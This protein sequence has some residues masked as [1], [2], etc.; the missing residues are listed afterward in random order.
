M[1]DSSTETEARSDGR[2]SGK[3]GRQGGVR[4]R[5]TDVN[6][7]VKAPE[8]AYYESKHHRPDPLYQ[9]GTLDTTEGGGGV[10]GEIHNSSTA[11]AEARAHNLVTAARALDPTD[12]AVPRELVTLPEGTV[13][14]SGSAKTA[15]EGMEDIELALDDM[16]DNPALTGAVGPA[17]QA[18]AEEQDDDGDADNDGKPDALERDKGTGSERDSTRPTGD[19]PE[20]SGSVGSPMPGSQRPGSTRRGK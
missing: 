6:D 5:T 11:F 3:R 20:G 9:Y 10:H 14:V 17:Q 1:T 16:A 8:G 7:L 18:A 15:E 13:T 19:R 2:T 4:A 12:R